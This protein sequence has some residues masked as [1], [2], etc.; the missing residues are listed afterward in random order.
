LAL[1]NAT[2]DRRLRLHHR[3][4][5]GPSR[6][7]DAP[8]F[9]RKRRQLLNELLH[10]DFADWLEPN[11]SL[12]G[13]HVAAWARGGVDLE[14]VVEGLGTMSVKLHTL[15]RYHL[16]SSPRQGVVF[17]YGAVDL[18]DIER[19]LAKLHEALAR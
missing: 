5:F 15:R 1:L 17:G 16:S 10:R 18:P 2:A 3:R 12:Y 6:P 11:P 4:P 13:M 19:G 14:E 9:Y 8:D 7:Q